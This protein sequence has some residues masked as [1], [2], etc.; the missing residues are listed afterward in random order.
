MF[1][2]IS[3]WRFVLW[4]YVLVHLWLSWTAVIWLPIA[5]ALFILA[6]ILAYSFI[7]MTS[8]YSIL[9]KR[10]LYIAKILLAFL[11]PP[12]VYSIVFLLD[13]WVLP[14]P[15][16]QVYT[17]LNL[18]PLWLPLLC[19]Y[20]LGLFVRLWPTLY[21]YELIL[22]LF[23]LVLTFIHAPSYEILFYPHPGALFMSLFIYISVESL[24]LISLKST[25]P[26]SAKVWTNRTL[27]GIL[28]FIL[29]LSL[30]CM[31]LYQ[32]ISRDLTKHSSGLLKPTLN[33]FDFNKSLSLENEINLGT[34][35]LL[36]VHLNKE[37][38]NRLL[39]K[40]HEL[41]GYDEKSGFF[42][43]D[44]YHPLSDH[45]PNQPIMLKEQ[46]LL[47]RESIEQD[48]FLVNLE[49]NALFSLDYA[50]KVTPLRLENKERRF[51][52]AYQVTSQAILAPQQLESYTQLE[53]AGHT[54]LSQAEKN[55][56]LKTGDI[57]EILHLA[58]DIVSEETSGY[59]QAQMIETYLK[60]NYL[61]SLKP[62]AQFLGKNTKDSIEKFLFESR[63]G[64][65]TYFAFAMALMTRGLG[66]PTRV[67]S[68]FFI[69][70]KDNLMGYFPV[71][72]QQAH[73]WVEIYFDD[74]GWISFDPTS[75]QIASDSLDSLNYD[76][77][78]D[79]LYP[80]VEELLSTRSAMSYIAQNI[81]YQELGSITKEK[82]HWQLWSLLLIVLLT[83][84]YSLLIFW[85]HFSSKKLT[86]KDTVRH[87]V[88]KL[89][90]TQFLLTKQS[91]HPLTFFKDKPLL[92]ALY[93]KALFARSFSMADAHE[94]LAEIQKIS[95]IK[96]LCIFN[97]IRIFFHPSWIVQRIHYAKNH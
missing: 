23:C 70:A 67:I 59:R 30:L 77:Q 43:L 33:S 7:K 26:F 79:N 90:L 84:I 24:Y 94:F 75:Q 80:F 74:F 47:G 31:F 93:R 81:H 3:L 55:I 89:L 72:A 88:K 53:N 28:G 69:D 6:D 54:Q 18:D 34:N 17:H 87:A 38:K 35:L 41:A 63:K 40:R 10:Q 92:L 37:F 45:N 68:G 42:V 82:K 14:L 58:Q 27:V 51:R 44:K 97:K 96:D 8:R 11:I 76:Y 56:Y 83:M 95:N 32:F 78:P 91:P 13:Q 1:S 57:K 25:Q 9:Q 60:L 61:Y 71:K 52:G 50:T 65:C 21:S 46:D 2:P 49:K 19:F 29:P 85:A 5:L 73:A 15:L 86:P 4:C 12:I 64:Y 66:L 39:F 62:G 22:R 48:Y 20:S 36:F 16:A